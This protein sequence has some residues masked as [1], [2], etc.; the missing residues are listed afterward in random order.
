[1]PESGKYNYDFQGYL[2]LVVEDNMI[3]YRLIKTMLA[4][5]NLEFL[6]ASDGKSAV[7]LC[8]ERPDIDLVLMDIQLPLMSGLDATRAILENRPGLPIIATTANAFH[9]DY[10]ACMEAGCKGFITK[11]IAFERL[12]SLIR[13]ILNTGRSD[14]GT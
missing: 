12:F 2:V 10:T 13:S 4:K 8:N 7:K 6:Y 11:P 9:E 14:E 3:S 5:V 1:M